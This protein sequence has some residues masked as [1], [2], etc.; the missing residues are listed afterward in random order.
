MTALVVTAASTS[1]MAF[2]GSYD[3]VGTLKS[4]VLGQQNA[5]S[6][7]N[8]KTADGLQCEFEMEYT[9]AKSG[10]TQ[11]AY[12]QLDFTHSAQILA[13]DGSATPLAPFALERLADNSNGLDAYS[14]AQCEVSSA[15]VVLQYSKKQ[16]SGWHSRKNHT[17][18]MTFANGK[19]TSVNG[20]NF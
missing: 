14:I 20:C 17:L 7:K 9:E 15:G 12:R 16:T 19:I 2:D 18:R 1:A 11:Q 6:L 3:C 5:L 13:A 10:V 8:G 4:T